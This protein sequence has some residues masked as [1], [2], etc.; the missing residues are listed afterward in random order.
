MQK[1]I[2]QLKIKQEEQ[3][4]NDK[5]AELQKVI[6][7]KEQIKITE[8]ETEEI[9]EQINFLNLELKE[10]SLEHEKEVIDLNILIEQE[11][12]LVQ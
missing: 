3:I 1:Q 2:E 5:K 4:R 6:E 8:E 9:R 11:R 12:Q 10:S 7:L